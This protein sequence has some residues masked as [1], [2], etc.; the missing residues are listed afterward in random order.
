MTWLKLTDTNLF[1]MEGGT[2]QFL[3][4]VSVVPNP[5]GNPNEFQ[6]NLTDVKTW[7]TRFSPSAPGVLAIEWKTGATP[8]TKFIPPTPTL[9][10]VA[11]KFTEDVVMKIFFDASRGNVRKYLPKVLYYLESVGLGDRDA[12]LMALG[13]IR[14]ETAGF[15]PIS[16]GISRFN[17]SPGGNPFD[18]YDFRGSGDLGNGAFGDGAR[19]KGRGFVQLTGKFNYTKFSNRIYKDNRLVD[20][21]DLANDPDV[22]AKLLAE[23]LK[24]S[25]SCWRPALQPRDFPKARK[26]V[27]GGTHGVREF[28]T[29][30]SQGEKLVS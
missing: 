12:I 5:S 16:E 6:L 10:A 4:E 29:A 21:P 14:A 23:F 18:L 7:M 9:G 27:N 3:A 13:T 20:V 24:D 30:F 28:A 2:E 26:C 19:F 8:P 1:L 22:A 17:T 11:S 25:V 15:E